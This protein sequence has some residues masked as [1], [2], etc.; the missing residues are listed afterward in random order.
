MGCRGNIGAGWAAMG[1]EHTGSVSPHGDYNHGEAVGEH[2][3]P[4]AGGRNPGLCKG[5]SFP[6]QLVLWERGNAPPL[7]GCDRWSLDLPF[8][9][10]FQCQNW[11][12]R[13]TWKIYPNIY[14]NP[15]PHPY[16]Q[17][18]F[19]VSLCKQFRWVA[20]WKWW[21]CLIKVFQ[22]KHWNSGSWFKGKLPLDCAHASTELFSARFCAHKTEFC[23]LSS[24][25]SDWGSAESLSSS[26]W[27]PSSP[28]WQWA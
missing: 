13:D 5:C 27:W 24:Q 12:C 19:Q 11:G 1:K 2:R 16:P 14:P 26:G 18:I 22:H 23:V 6:W 8:W 17:I 9:K 10:F 7:D 4:S 20:L 21:K 28:S 15:P 25:V 3:K